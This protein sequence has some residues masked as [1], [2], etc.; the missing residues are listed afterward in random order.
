MDKFQKY[1]EV[2]KLSEEHE[3]EIYF[4]HACSLTEA[5]IHSSQVA[6]RIREC[7][8]SVYVASENDDIND[9][10][11][12]PTPFDIYLGDVSRMKAAEFMVFNS[13]GSHQD[14]TIWE[15]GWTCGNNDAHLA[16]QTAYNNLKPYLSHMEKAFAD[17]GIENQFTNIVERTFKELLQEIN[18]KEMIVYSSNERLNNPQFYK[19][20]TDVKYGIA[21]A[22]ANHLVFGGVDTHGRFVG[23]EEH[24]MNALKEKKGL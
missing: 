6:D 13:N 14:G 15:S 10:T 23:N 1:N 2:K 4:G 22:G 7:G 16:I 24:M 21:S 12:D 9:K 11:K 19:G 3:N 17:Y 20:E 5:K 18:Y 8:Y